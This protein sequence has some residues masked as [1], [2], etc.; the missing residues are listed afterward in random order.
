VYVVNSLLA[1]TTEAKGVE[2]PAVRRSGAMCAIG[3]GCFLLSGGAGDDPDHLRSDLYL[4]DTC[5]RLWT[6][7]LEVS[8]GGLLNATQHASVLHCTRLWQSFSR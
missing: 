2:R 6:K 8:V 1:L 4:F 7:L 5:T 3:K